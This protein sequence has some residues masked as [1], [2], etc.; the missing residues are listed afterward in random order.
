MTFTGIAVFAWSWQL[1][2]LFLIVVGL[3]GRR[4]GVVPILASLQRAILSFML[5]KLIADVAKET[6]S[7]FPF[8]Q[9][10]KGLRSGNKQEI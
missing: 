8:A 6:W 1:A 9:Q 10:I 4:R 7:W 5:I 3:G 2:F